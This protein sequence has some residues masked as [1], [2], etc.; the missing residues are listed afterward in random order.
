MSK[1]QP[2]IRAFDPQTDTNFVASSMKWSLREGPEGEGL[3][4]WQFFSQF[5]P[6]IERLLQ[7]FEPL[8][9][10][11]PENPRVIW[12]YCITRGQ[13]LIYVYV[14]APLRR[15][16]IATALLEASDLDLSQPFRYWFR[17]VKTKR[18]ERRFPQA[19]YAQPSN[20]G[21]GMFG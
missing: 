4:E 7:H 10:V 6:V 12:G 8:I 16:G 17:T 1:L 13:N 14:K 5:N 15:A 20:T 19:S 11:D 9:A 3:E 2:L 21:V 18:L